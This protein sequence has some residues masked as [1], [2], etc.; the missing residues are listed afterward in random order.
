[1]QGEVTS[2]KMSYAEAEIQKMSLKFFGL[3]FNSV[4]WPFR[5]S[6][7]GNTGA[8]AGSWGV[9]L[10]CLDAGKH[11][12]REEGLPSGKQ[13]PPRGGQHSKGALAVQVSLLVHPRWRP[14]MPGRSSQRGTNMARFLDHRHRSQSG[15]DARPAP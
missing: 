5:F 10:G 12:T 8:L 7:L 1:M 11:T 13:A 14:P 15:L 6:H 3:F 9:G 4:S 2:F